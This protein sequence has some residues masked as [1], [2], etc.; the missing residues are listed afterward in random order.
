MLGEGGQ[1][2][3]APT[4][5]SRPRVNGV[6]GHVDGVHRLPPGSLAGEGRQQGAVG[7][8]QAYV[9]LGGQLRGEARGVHISS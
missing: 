6:G 5:R 3:R 8:G 4:R 1:R 7:V 2:L 9:E